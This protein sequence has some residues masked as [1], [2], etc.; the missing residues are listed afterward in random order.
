M[1]QPLGCATTFSRGIDIP[2]T[3]L[4]R[5]F[6]LIHRVQLVHMTNDVLHFAFAVDFPRDVLER[7][8]DFGVDPLVHILDDFIVMVVMRVHVQGFLGL[9]SELFLAL[10]D[11]DNIAVVFVFEGI[12]VVF[13]CVSIGET[14]DHTDLITKNILDGDESENEEYA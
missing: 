6:E 12:I 2:R 8:D 7:I 1:E 11:R 4:Q 14:F 3:L 5:N 10:G 13:F 9:R